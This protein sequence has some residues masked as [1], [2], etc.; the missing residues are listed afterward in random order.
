MTPGPHRHEPLHALENRLKRGVLAL[1]A[2]LALG[3]LAGPAGA[4]EV[5]RRSV[6]PRPRVAGTATATPP[7]LP[8]RLRD[9]HIEGEISVPQVL[10]ITARDQRRFMDFQHH[11]YLQTSVQL[12]AA[13]PLPRWVAVTHDAPN[14]PR[15]ETSR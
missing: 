4:S 13:T 11:R 5:A 15:K 9:V 10:F 12:G 3:A 7:S 2:L 6:P 1:M 14:S 8:R